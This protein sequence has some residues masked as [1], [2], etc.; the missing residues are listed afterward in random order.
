MTP[1]GHA[2]TSALVLPIICNVSTMSTIESPLA[3]QERLVT[4]PR[5]ERARRLAMIQ[6]PKLVAKAIQLVWMWD[7]NQTG[8]GLIDQQLEDELR[9]SGVR[10]G[11]P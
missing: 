8:K 3:A 9:N 2:Q 6:R 11:P 5:S 10:F 4:R 7:L 1:Q